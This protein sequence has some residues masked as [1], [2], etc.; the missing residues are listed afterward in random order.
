MM[1]QGELLEVT[2][3]YNTGNFSFDGVELYG[4]DMCNNFGSLDFSPSFLSATPD[5]SSEISSPDQYLSSGPSDG[6]HNC[7]EFRHQLPKLE[8]SQMIGNS[9][10]G[11]IFDEVSCLSEL[12]ELE[13]SYYSKEVLSNN[14][15]YSLEVPSAQ[16]SICFPQEDVE[17]DIQLSICYL[18]Q[19]YG[20]AIENGQVDLV[21]AIVKR[22]EEKADPTGETYQRLVYYFVQSLEKHMD[23]LRQESFKIFKPAFLALYQIFPYGRFAHFLANSEILNAMPQD[24]EMTIVDFDIGEGLQWPSLFEFLGRKKHPCLVKLILI[25]WDE[26]NNNAS[27]CLW[28]FEETKR[29]LYEHARCCNL[30]LEIVEMSMEELTEETKTKRSEWITFNCMTNLPHMGRSRSTKSVIEFLKIA[31][32]SINCDGSTK[33]GIITFGDGL[34]EERKNDCSGFGSFLEARMLHL[35]ALLESM[36]LHLPFQLIEARLA[37]ECLFVAPYMSSFACLQNWEEISFGVDGFSMLGLE[38]KR[39]SQDSIAEGQELLG[40]RGM[41]GY[42]IKN[43]GENEN[44]IVLGY[45]GNTLVKV[46][47]WK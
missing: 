31:K 32:G 22:F 29:Q 27:T 42:W 24:A 23:Y 38:G 41:S 34:M 36:D 3:P 47:C 11:V 45:K 12:M 30:K 4:L 9:E 7:L 15:D 5:Y 26:D 33:S 25:R 21:D 46:S 19:A 2:W 44:E 18:I 14:K 17:I 40:E 20:E 28:K 8:E 37:M 16:L 1:Q 13:T 43:Q 6:S 35:H 39:L 10:T